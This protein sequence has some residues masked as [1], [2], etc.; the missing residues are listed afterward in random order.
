MKRSIWNVGGWIA[1]IFAV[2]ASAASASAEGNTWYAQRVTQSAGGVAVEHIWSKG[3]SL[4]SE[5]VVGAHP[6]VTVVHGDRYWILDRLSGEGIS[7][8]RHPNAV[9]ADD[10]NRRPF[11]D[12]AERLQAEGGEFVGDEEITPEFS[13]R[14]IK[15]TDDRGRQEVCVRDDEVGLPVFLR[16][17][18]R[19]TNRNATIQYVNW[20]KDLEIDTSFFVPDGGGTMKSYTYEDYVKATNGGVVGPAPVFYPQLLHG[21]REQ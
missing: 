18:D 1:G 4:R 2:A 10:P 12:E 13:C 3:A 21:A 16:T 20:I 17:W 5:V 9:G 14:L 6:V 19:S 8:A 15:L 11:G 7:V